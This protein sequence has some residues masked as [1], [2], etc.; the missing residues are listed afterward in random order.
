MQANADGKQIIELYWLVHTQW[1]STYNDEKSIGNKYI[2]WVTWAWDTQ[3]KEKHYS[4]H[5]DSDELS[6]NISCD[7]NCANRSTDFIKNKM[8]QERNWKDLL[9][10]KIVLIPSLMFERYCFPWN[11]GF[12]VVHKV[13]KSRVVEASY[14]FFLLVTMPLMYDHLFELS[15]FL[16]FYVYTVLVH[17]ACY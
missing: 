12:G 14:S 9:T 10:P 11:I 15:G 4:L 13:H 1:S 16:L 7:E 3:S 5:L 2:V 8:V 6:N 17:F